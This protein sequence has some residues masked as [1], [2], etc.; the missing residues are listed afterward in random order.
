MRNSVYLLCIL[1]RDTKLI[2]ALRIRNYV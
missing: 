1:G 2:I